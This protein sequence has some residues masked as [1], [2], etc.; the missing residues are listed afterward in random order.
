MC[1]QDKRTSIKPIQFNVLWSTMKLKYFI[2]LNEMR[3]YRVYLCLLR[4]NG[5]FPHIYL[6][7]LNSSFYKYVAQNKHLAGICHFSFR[8]CVH[9]TKYEGLSLLS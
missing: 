5:R 7:H 1:V 6:K 8:L 4:S 9:I 3:I 2:E